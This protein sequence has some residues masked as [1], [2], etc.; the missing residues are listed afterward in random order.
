MENTGI[1]E[2]IAKLVSQGEKPKDAQN[3]TDLSDSSQKNNQPEKNSTNNFIGENKNSFCK[4]YNP[5]ASVSGDKNQISGPRASLPPRNKIDL[6]YSKN[7]AN[8]NAKNKGA[9][10]LELINLHNAH[11]KKI[12]EQNK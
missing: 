12:S 10:V 4:S 5:L 6:S 1:W 2:L 11:S 9:N 3:N 7:V 8:K